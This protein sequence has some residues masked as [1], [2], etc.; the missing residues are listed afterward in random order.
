MKKLITILT[1]AAASFSASGQNKESIIG[2][3][4][5]SA[6]AGEN[7]QLNRNGSFSFNDYN[8][9]TKAAENLYGTWRLQKSTVTLMYDDRPQQRF[10]MKK[11]KAGKWMLTKAGGFRFVKGIPADCSAQ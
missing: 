8:A 1:I 11:D 5:V 2:C 6:R 4:K 7:L 10:T 9:M 3:W